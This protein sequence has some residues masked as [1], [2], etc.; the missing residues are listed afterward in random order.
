[1]CRT[2]GDAAW[3]SFDFLIVLA[4]YMPGGDKIAVRMTLSLSMSL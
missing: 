1:M 2:D 3:N 4:C